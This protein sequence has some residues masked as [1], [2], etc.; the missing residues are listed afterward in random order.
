M[1]NFISSVPAAFLSFIELILNKVL[2]YGPAAL[3]LIGLWLLGWKIFETE[4]S[5]SSYAELY[6][7]IF[8]ALVATIVVG[9]FSLDWLELSPK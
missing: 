3:L 2:E 4:D 5:D 1:N 8:A 6:P 7:I 9:I